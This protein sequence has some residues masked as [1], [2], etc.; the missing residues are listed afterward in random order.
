MII[1]SNHLP[2]HANRNTL[3]GEWEFAWDE[4]ALVAQAKVRK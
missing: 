3:T 2:I 1:V 4:D